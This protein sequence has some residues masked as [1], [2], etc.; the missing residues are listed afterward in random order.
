MFRLDVVRTIENEKLTLEAPWLLKHFHVFFQ[1]FF[2]SLPFFLISFVITEVLQPY[3]EKQTS[4]SC[5]LIVSLAVGYLLVRKQYSPTVIPE[6]TQAQFLQAA[7][8]TLKEYGFNITKNNGKFLFASC[9]ANRIHLSDSFYAAYTQNAILVF[10]IC[11]LPFPLSVI[12]AR[13]VLAS[14]KSRCKSG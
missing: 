10:C 11:E 8:P 13:A 3:I 4:L 5:L 6:T 1:A 9:T 2:N 14:I 7:M 12:K